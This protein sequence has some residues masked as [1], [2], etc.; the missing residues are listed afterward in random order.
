LC[1]LFIFE[2]R[3]T[4]EQ[5][6]NALQILRTASGMPCATYTNGTFQTC[7]NQSNQ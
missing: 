1:W 6:V 4:L 7:A 5:I 2:A 3:M